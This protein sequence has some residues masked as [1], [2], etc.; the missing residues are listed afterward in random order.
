MGSLLGC[1][2]NLPELNTTPLLVPTERQLGDTLASRCIRSTY[3]D[4][5]FLDSGAHQRM[6]RV[7]VRGCRRPASSSFVV[8]R[9]PLSQGRAGKQ[10]LGMGFHRKTPHRSSRAASQGPGRIN[11]KGCRSERGSAVGGPCVEKDRWLRMPHKSEAPGL[12]PQPSHLCPGALTPR[13]QVAPRPTAPFPEVGPTAP[14]NRDRNPLTN[15][16]RI[17]REVHRPQGWKVQTLTLTSGVLGFPGLADWRSW[18]RPR[19]QTR[20][21]AGGPAG[22]NCRSRLQHA[23]VSV[24]P[25][26]IIVKREASCRVDESP[27]WPVP[28]TEI[29]RH[30]ACSRAL[31]SSAQCRVPRPVS[32]AALLETDGSP[33]VD[34]LQLLHPLGSPTLFNSLVG[35]RCL[36]RG[37]LGVCGPQRTRE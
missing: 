37:C 2:Q 32:C 26:A 31:C 17:P 36:W 8:S 10:P 12:R 5:C 6:R 30:L 20:G 4:S 18:R 3:R 28:S 11:L 33:W 9:G 25:P 22:R 19:A 1:H 24:L 13:P 7:G 15:F 27:V 21:G 14:G 23:F 35:A 16:S 34:R 29:Y